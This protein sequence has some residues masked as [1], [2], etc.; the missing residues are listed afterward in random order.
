MH[1]KKLKVIIGYKCKTYVVYNIFTIYC[2]SWMCMHDLYI[3]ENMGHLK[4][5]NR[6]LRLFGL[7]RTQYNE[8]IYAERKLII[9]FFF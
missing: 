2:S 9:L 6:L 4:G 3:G 5:L 1:V 7:V 8:S